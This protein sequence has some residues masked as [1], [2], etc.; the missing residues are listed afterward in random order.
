MTKDPAAE[1]LTI[2][3]ERFR[4]PAPGEWRDDLDLGPTGFGLDSISLV[5]LLIVCEDRLG[6]PFPYTLFDE[7]PITVG[8]LVAHAKQTG[9]ATARE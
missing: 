4:A 7:G 9:G 5:E 3:S 1:I 2:V 8:K 6:C